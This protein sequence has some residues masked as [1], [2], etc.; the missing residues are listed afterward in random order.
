M[1]VCTYIRITVWKD[2]RMYVY[3]DNSVKGWKFNSEYECM[4]VYKDN[5]VKGWKDVRI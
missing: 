5:S 3:K 1:N 2:E 4:Y